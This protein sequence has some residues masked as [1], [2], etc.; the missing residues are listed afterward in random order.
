MDTPTILQIATCALSPYL[1][2]CNTGNK[3]EIWHIL[4]LVRKMGL[5]N[6]NITTLEPRFQIM[7]S[8]GRGNIGT[9]DNVAKI[10]A[11]PVGNGLCFD[12]HSVK[13]IRNVTQTDGDG[14]TGDLILIC[15]GNREFSISVTGKINAKKIEKC[16]T[17]PSCRRL[18]C[19]DAEIALI[20]EIEKAA[21]AQ[22]DQELIGKFGADRIKWPSTKRLVTITARSCANRAAQIAVD[23]F[24]GLPDE[25]KRRVMN[26]VHHI[27]RAPA[28]YLCIVSRHKL[29]YYQFGSP[30]MDKDTWIPRAM[31]RDI[32]IDV[33][34]EEK[35]ISF[36]QV[37][38]N[39]GIGSSLRSSW[40]LNAMLANL[41]NITLISSQFTQ[42]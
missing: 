1:T 4:V 8:L 5:T 7:E 29:I 10:L 33:F 26:D 24:N 3:Y 42:S 36:T 9:L 11:M 34:H 23:R 12:G 30:T 27:E 20:K 32:Y 31:V 39:N 14:G 13:N 18:G 35:Q 6:E 37:K 40:N 19:S 16:L 38:F 22:L 21:P 2:N 17:N 28:D 25:E 15:E 41:Y